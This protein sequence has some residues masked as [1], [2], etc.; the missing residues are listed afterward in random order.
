VWEAIN[1]RGADNDI[2]DLDVVGFSDR[3]LTFADGPLV[4]SPADLSA[5]LSI[6]LPSED[7]VL[8][9]PKLPNFSSTLSREEAE[10]LLSFLTVD[11]VRIPLV[12]GFFATSD[13]ITYLFNRELQV[14]LTVSSVHDMHDVLYCCSNFVVVDVIRSVI[15]VYSHHRIF[16]TRRSLT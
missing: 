10:S 2:A 16:C 7:D 13:H 4:H 6:Q 11:Y 8:H 14:I 5:I 1:F 3:H 15:V 12:L 9:A